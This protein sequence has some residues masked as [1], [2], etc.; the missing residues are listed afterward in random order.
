M[1]EGSPFAKASVMSGYPLDQKE[2]DAVDKALKAA[3]ASND[4]APSAA[5]GGTAGYGKFRLIVRRGDRRR[6]RATT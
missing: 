5:N 3:K 4:S 6:R 2:K 1:T